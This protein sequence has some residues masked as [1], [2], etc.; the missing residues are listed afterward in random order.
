MP[1]PLLLVPLAKVAVTAT[2]AAAGAY[3]AKKVYDK[4]QK[5]KEEL[6]AANR[7]LE[8]KLAIYKNDLE[9]DDDDF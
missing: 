8:E 4:S 1:L 6:R 2:V 5:E 9:D 7:K 3:G